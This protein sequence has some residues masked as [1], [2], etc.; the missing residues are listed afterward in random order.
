MKR[1]CKKKKCYSEP[2]WPRFT[3]I[4]TERKSKNGE[5][6]MVCVKRKRE[7][8]M[9]VN[10][11][12]QKVL[13]FKNAYKIQEIQEMCFEMSFQPYWGDDVYKKI[14]IFFHWKLWKDQRSHMK[15][16]IFFFSLLMY[17]SCLCRL[18][19]LTYSPRRF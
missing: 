14:W 6:I 13:I 2:N 8:E 19:S 3:N 16:E 17:Y 11:L 7:R 12:N 9:E 5:I 10:E 4:S 15:K 18:H 1:E